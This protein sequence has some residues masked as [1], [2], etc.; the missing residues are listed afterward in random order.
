MATFSVTRTYKVEIDDEVVERL[1]KRDYSN[2]TTLVDTI[3]RQVD[4]G[5]LEGVLY[6]FQEE[7][8]LVWDAES[9]IDADATVLDEARYSAEEIDFDYEED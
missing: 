4:G 1:A 8:D 7:G 5:N 3:T 6:L 2:L 9:L